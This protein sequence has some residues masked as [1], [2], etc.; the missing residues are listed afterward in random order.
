[1]CAIGEEVRLLPERL[2]MKSVPASL[3]EGF[4]TA[5]KQRM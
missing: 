5:E 3:N 1:M 4:Y 2:Q